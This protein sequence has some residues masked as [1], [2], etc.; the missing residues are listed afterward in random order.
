MP[1][2][3]ITDVA[4]D[5]PD[6]PTDPVGVER[7]GTLLERAEEIIKLAR[8]DLDEAVTAGRVSL[9]LLKQVEAEMVAA[10]LRNPNGYTSESQS[11]GPISTSYS[12]DV[13]TASPLLRL[14]A[15]QRKLIGAGPGGR[16][17]T[18]TPRSSARRV[19]NRRWC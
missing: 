8:P 5:F 12:L 10:V 16:A 6:V 18:L 19:F 3:S 1:Y 17:F 7:V 15:E 14:T 13:K 9:V 2:A 4:V 11:V